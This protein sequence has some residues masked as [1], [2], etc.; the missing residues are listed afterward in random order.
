MTPPRLE[1]QKAP[2]ASKFCDE[3]KFNRFHGMLIVL[4]ILTLFFDG[5]D[6]QILSY[7]LPEVIKEWDLS[8]VEAGSLASYGLLGLMI[9]TAGIGM[10]ADMIGRK[11]PLM[12]G[13]V[14]FSFFCGALYWAPDF[15]TFCILRFISG[16]GIGGVLT[17]IITMATEFAPAVIRARMVAAMMAGFMIGPSIAGWLS[18]VIVPA[19]GWRSVLLVSFLPLLLL[20]VIHFFMPESI[21]FLAQKGRIEEAIGVLRRIERAAGARPASWAKESFAVPTSAKAGIRQL[22]ASRLAIMTLLVWLVYFGNLLVIYGLTTWLPTLL[23]GAGIPLVRSFGYTSL[24]HLGGA[25]GTVA[26]GVTMDRFGRKPGLFSSYILAAISIWLF[27]R[28]TGSEAGLYIIGT[29]AGFFVNGALSAQHA[30]TAEIYPTAVR[31]TGVGW[32]LTMGRFGAICGPLLGGYFQSQGVSFRQY[33]DMFA[34][35]CLICAVLVYFYRVN[36][37]G[38]TLE[39]VEKRLSAGSGQ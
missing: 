19:H 37:K 29:A 26:I 13:L 25:I 2:N 28:L 38:E 10:L 30:V 22:F 15:K 39:S 7:I 34:L 3:L 12:I 8:P 31:S 33:F 5:Y 4:G 6:S 14:L 17:L 21:R 36:V 27:A 32:A 18:M 1:D 9:G 23:V 20:P 35:P 24:N 16:L 11:I